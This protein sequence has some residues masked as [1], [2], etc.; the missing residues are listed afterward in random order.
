MQPPPLSDE[1]FEY[2][3]AGREIGRLDAGTSAFELARTQ[4]IL[5]RVLPAAP[6]TIAIVQP[7]GSR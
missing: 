5:E 7:E 6:A 4:D 3:D 2:Y 1:F